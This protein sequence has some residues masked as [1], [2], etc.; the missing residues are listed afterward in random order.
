MQSKRTLITDLANQPIGVRCRE[1]QLII[2]STAVVDAL[3]QKHHYSHKTTK[4]RMLS[5]VVL[6]DEY[7]ID[8][9]GF[10]QLGYGIRPH[11]KH[12]I[13]P[14]ITTKNY[15]EFDRMWLS[16]DLPKF[17]ETTVIGMLLWF[18]KRWNLGIDYVI[19]Y[20][21]GSV[22]N[23]GTIYKASNAIPI[24]KVPVDFYQLASGERVHPVSMWHRHKTRA[25]ETMEAIYPGIRHI[26]DEYQYRFLY[27]LDNKKR[28]QWIKEA[29]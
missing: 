27:I 21:D 5:M 24:G 1:Y 9:K 14:H 17:S 11:M 25:K 15:A 19:T 13:S 28:K 7:D 8:P 26:R 10:I 22:G 2:Q 3:V 16:D 29:Q 12:T 4:N 18:I 20:A 23:R 6:H